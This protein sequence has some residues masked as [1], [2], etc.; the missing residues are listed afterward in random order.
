MKIRDAKMIIAAAMVSALLLALTAS[1]YFQGCITVYLSRFSSFSLLLSRQQQNLSYN[2]NRSL[3]TTFLKFF[4]KI[5]K[6]PIFPEISGF[7]L[8][9]ALRSYSHLPFSYAGKGKMSL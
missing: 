9:A 8:I 1:E 5:L 2:L 4:Q 7:F 6:T 3:S